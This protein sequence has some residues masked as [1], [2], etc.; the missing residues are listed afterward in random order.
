MAGSNKQKWSYITKYMPD[1][2]GRDGF[3]RPAKMVH[4]DRT[5]NIGDIDRMVTDG[6]IQS[7]DK[8]YV[9]DL[10]AM[11]YDKLLGSGKTTH[12]VEIKSSTILQVCNRKDTRRRRKSRTFG[13]R[14]IAHAGRVNTRAQWLFCYMIYKP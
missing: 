1:H 3:K 2:F 6:Y 11:G 4:R 8:K 12:A 10:T 7:V 5:I 14:R 9:I 13:R